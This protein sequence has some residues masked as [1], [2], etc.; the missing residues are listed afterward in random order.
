MEGHPKWACPSV[1][2]RIIVT[3]RSNEVMVWSVTLSKLVNYPTQYQ[4]SGVY[5]N[6]K[7]SNCTENELCISHSIYR[8][9]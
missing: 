8:V 9:S 7:S 5:I 6:T 3:S 2:L 1:Y 4:W